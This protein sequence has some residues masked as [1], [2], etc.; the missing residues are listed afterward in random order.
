MWCKFNVMFSNSF[1]ELSLFE[2]RLEKLFID[3]NSF[4]TLLLKARANV[5][6]AIVS[7]RSSLPFF[8]P[9]IEGYAKLAC[10][11]YR[12]FGEIDDCNRF[13]KHRI[14]SAGVSVNLYDYED[15]VVANGDRLSG[16]QLELSCCSFWAFKECLDYNV[17]AYKNDDHYH[18]CAA[19]VVGQY[20]QFL[21]GKQ[22]YANFCSYHNLTSETDDNCQR[23]RMKSIKYWKLFPAIVMAVVAA[24]VIL[25]LTC[26]LC[27]E[28][29]RRKKD[30]PS[31]SRQPNNDIA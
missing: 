25:I 24:L 5:Y 20:R 13:Y 2:W 9:E 17:D 16:H 14:R 12:L 15:K 28:C 22:I 18:Y 1:T 21:T 7:T 27:H 10:Y 3:S 19:I 4:N 8:E 6:I 30:R 11:N 31:Y 26:C 29:R 23:Y